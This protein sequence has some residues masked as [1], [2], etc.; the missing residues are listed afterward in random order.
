MRIRPATSPVC[1]VA[2][3]GDLGQEG[4]GQ[5]QHAVT[6]SSRMETATAGPVRAQVAEQPLHEPRVVGLAQDLVFVE[7]VLGHSAA[8][9]SCSSCCSRTSSA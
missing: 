3:D 5:L 2:V 8:S 1:D 6:M 4:P 9:S 7:F